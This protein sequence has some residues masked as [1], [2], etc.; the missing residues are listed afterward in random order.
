MEEVPGSIPGQALSFFP[1]AWVYLDGFVGFVFGSQ[2]RR[3][4]YIGTHVGL[5]FSLFLLIL[6]PDSAGLGYA[7]KGTACVANT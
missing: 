3:D 1:V 4:Q 5:L 2:A 7:L 6:R